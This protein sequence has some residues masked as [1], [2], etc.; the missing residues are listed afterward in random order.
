MSGTVTSI[1]MVS[2][3]FF[4][5]GDGEYTRQ[6]VRMLNDGATYN[7]GDG[8]GEVPAKVAFRA[9]DNNEAAPHTVDG[10]LIDTQK[11]E[12]ETP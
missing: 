4:L 7:V 8:D 1:V 10:N 5:V 9:L 11:K 2:D 3:T 12:S 6:S